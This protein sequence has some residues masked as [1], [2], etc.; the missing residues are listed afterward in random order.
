[1]PDVP[2]NHTCQPIFATDG[3]H[4]GAFDELARQ[5]EAIS[6]QNNGGPTLKW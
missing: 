4:R 5:I 2:A 3:I 1:M 6:R